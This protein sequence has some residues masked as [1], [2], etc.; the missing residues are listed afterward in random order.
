MIYTFGEGRD[1]GVD[2]GCI[3]CY[4]CFICVSDEYF[5]ELKLFC[6][7]LSF[8]AVNGQWLLVVIVEAPEHNVLS[9]RPTERS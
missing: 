9:H 5:W 7:F 3:R 6:L 2:M 8:S 4:G 1:G